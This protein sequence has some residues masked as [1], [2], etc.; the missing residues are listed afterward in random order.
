MNLGKTL[1]VCAVL[2][3]IAVAQRAPESTLAV[4]SPSPLS[5]PKPRRWVLPVADGGSVTPSQPSVHGYLIVAGRQDITVKRES[6][7]ADA[8]RSVRVRLTPKTK[9]FT[10]YGG[11]YDP[12]QLRTGQYVWI[13][14]I[15]ADPAQAGIPSRAA[16]V[17][18]WST[19]PSDKPSQNVR[20][21][22]DRHK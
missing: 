1:L 19:D 11:A 3:T 16:A 18:L 17:V 4:P 5:H 21:S 14:Y 20:W 10:A 9:F 8:G 13:W 7:D 6:R 15:T 12:D 22:Y 2:W